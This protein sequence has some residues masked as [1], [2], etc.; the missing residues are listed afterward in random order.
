ML[1][2]G[3]WEIIITN[4]PSDDYELVAELYKENEMLAFITGKGGTRKIT[5][6]NSDKDVDIPFDWFMEALQVIKSKIK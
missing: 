6:Y 4:D 2:N 3:E 5:W 1:K